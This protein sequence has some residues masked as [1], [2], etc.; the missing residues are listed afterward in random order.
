MALYPLSQ[1]PNDTPNAPAETPTADDWFASQG[2]PGYGVWAKG[3]PGARAY[4]Q[5][6]QQ[7][8]IPGSP[9][10]EASVAQN[11]NIDPQT[12]QPWRAWSASQ[13]APGG[14]QVPADLR[15][16]GA[17]GAPQA[18]TGQPPS[19]RAGI[20]QWVTQQLAQYGIQPG[21]RGSGVGD[22]EYWADQMLDPVN[23][24]YS[25]WAGRIQRGVQG[26]QPPLA[27]GG[28]TAGYPAG[29]GPFGLGVQFPSA[30]GTG[31]LF[32]LGVNLPSMEGFEGS[33][34]YQFR[35]GEGLKALERSAAS[36]GTLLTGGTLKG[37]ER[38]GQNLA[39][40]EYANEYARRLG[41]T[42]LGLGAQ[43]QRFGQELGLGQFGLGA[44][45]QRYGQLLGLGQLGLGYGQM[46]AGAAGQQAGLGSTYAGQ[47]GN[48]L[49]GQAQGIGDW[50]T[51]RGN[52][53]A[54]GTV[55]GANAWQNALG[56]GT[57]LAQMY[58]L[59]RMMQPG[60]TPTGG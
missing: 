26:T 12:G 23:T 28:G 58:L 59:S 18:P 25:D 45:Q 4:E 49:G 53:A 7:G 34:G 1:L 43:Q 32:G 35:L 36:R 20:T 51:Q 9:G 21:P 38:Y 17:G 37:L 24:G 46:G 11:P 55:G 10:Y 19:D 47:A 39:S 48:L 15:T 29:N 60:T 56:Q 8:K 42:Q 16:T 54:A 57:N 31:G 52:A 40:Q 3:T 50:L 30:I 13:G 5:S 14:F 2:A 27:G 22:V 6:W 33:P 44:Q 41:E